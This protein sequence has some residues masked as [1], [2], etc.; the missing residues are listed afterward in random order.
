M[1]SSIAHTAPLSPGTHAYRLAGLVQRYHVHGSGPVCVAHS[2]GPGIFY[3]YLRMP[4][5]EEHLT[6]VYV[7]PIGTAEDSRLPSHP[8]GYTRERYSRFLEILINRLGVPKVHLLGHSHGAFVAA[9]HAL[10][11]PERLAGVVLYEGSPVTGPEHAAEAGRMVEEFAAEHSG[12][13]GLPGVLAA[14]DAMSRISSDEEAEA[15]AKGVLPSYFADFWGDEARYAPLR[16]A[17]QATYISGLDEDLAPDV[18]NDRAALR[19]LTLPALVIVGRHD[20]ICGV[21]WGRELHE[22]I[23]GSRLLILENSG[24]L[25][26]VEE[27]ALFA[28]AVR[29]FVLETTAEADGAA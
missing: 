21:R 13:P 11:R 15:V 3:E 8:H 16:D 27:P 28:D 9:H 29:S 6:M 24:H 25:G 17:V 23:P 10:H 20:V 2:G 7:E 14:F 19:D 26:H 4:A 5:L 18:V 1:H 12:H 22:L